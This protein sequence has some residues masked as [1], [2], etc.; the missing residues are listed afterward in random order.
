[1]KNYIALFLL[2]T[3]FSTIAQTEKF[4]GKYQLSNYHNINNDVLTRILNVNSDNT[5]SFHEYQNSKGF[6]NPKN[7]YGKGT[8]TA[9]GNYIYFHT[10]K[11]DITNKYTLNFNNSKAVYKSKHPRD[12]SNR[13]IIPHLLFL[14]TD[15][16][17]MERVKLD[18][19]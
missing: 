8:W 1:M 15:L 17:W 7:S 19:K 4:I 12:K 13:I 11:S 2:C 14:K 3:A 18:K 5:F 9:K 16:F 10:Q 6:I